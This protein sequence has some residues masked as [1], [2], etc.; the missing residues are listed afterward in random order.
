M[1]STAI[2]STMLASVSYDG[3]RQLLFLEF[4][5]GSVYCYLGVPPSIHQALLEAP[6]KGLYFHQHIRGQ[7]PF[8]KHSGNPSSPIA[9][10]NTT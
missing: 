5:S 3:F 6:S 8:T 9:Q 10:H 1:I 7:F 2:L 4:R